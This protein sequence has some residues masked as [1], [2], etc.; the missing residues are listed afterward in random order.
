ML[1]ARGK[2]GRELVA[3]GRIDVIIGPW[4]AAAVLTAGI[5]AAQLW[6]R[7]PALSDVS[8][9]PVPAAFHL[10][11]PSLYLFFG[12]VFTLW[13]AVSLLSLRRLEGFMIGVGVLYLLWR[14]SRWLGWRNRP[15]WRQELGVL[16][17]TLTI[18]AAFLTVGA[19]WR[20]PMLALAGPTQEYAVVDFHSHT[21]A[22]GDAAVPA[23]RAFDVEANRRWHRRAGFDAAFVTDHNRATEVGSA[24]S[25]GSAEDIV[26]CPGMEISAWRAHIVLLGGTMP[27][28]GRRYDDS[29]GGL[30]ALL[31]DSDSMYRALAV[32][33]LPEYE[34]YQWANLGR[35]I[36]AGV[37]GLE[38][39]NAAPQAS[40]LTRARRDSVIR[41][42]RAHDLFLTGVSDNHGWGAT[43]MAWSLVRAPVRRAGVALCHG[44]LEAL[45]RDGFSAVRVLERHRLRPDDW[46][47]L[48]LTPIGSVWE[49][50]RSMGTALTVSWIVWIWGV[51]ACY[52]RW[53]ARRLDTPG[54]RSGAANTA[55]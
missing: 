19:L 52:S 46:W 26:L 49:S 13:D 28:D 51:A 2:D 17:L 21:S 14:G 11:V 8:G 15:S 16:A 4:R 53:H 18:L 36:E 1:D 22:S 20:R 23:W 32:A 35:L 29:F 24:G 31:S 37:D 39:V 6:C 43:S 54:R 50:W 27:A 30:L 5:A 10:H 3:R 45:R 25:A 40:E 55:R 38:I 42:A 44:I 7:V 33:S 9:A 34:R 41:L 48:W 47:P 12:P